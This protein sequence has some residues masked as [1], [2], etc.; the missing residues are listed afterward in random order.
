MAADRLKAA[1][2]VGQL[3]VGG[4]ERQVH[5]LTM[6][7]RE[8]PA[9]PL[10][11]SMTGRIA[12]FGTRLRESGV[13]VIALD[14]ARLGICG[15]VTALVRLLRRSDVHL[16]HSFGDAAGAFSAAAAAVT[17]IPHVHAVR[18]GRYGRPHAWNAL[19]GAVAHLAAAVTVNSHALR[20]EMVRFYRVPAS[21]VLL[22]PSGVDGHRFVG[23]DPAALRRTL[24]LSGAPQIVYVGRDHPAKDIPTLIEVIR[25]TDQLWPEST[26]APCFVLVGHGLESH[27]R[28]AASAVRRVTVRSLGV[29]HEVDRVIAACDILLLT[30]RSESM[31]NVVLEAMAAGKAVVATDAGG[32]REAITDGR[33]GRLARVGDARALAAALLALSEDDETRR[34]LGTQARLH[35]ERE[36]RVAAARDAV[37]AVYRAVLSGAVPRPSLRWR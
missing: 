28:H 7:L 15:R 25:R 23:L 16:V 5:T 27:A 8:T 10:V 37:C 2:V 6:A 18:S 19:R 14:D 12:P 34:A 35:V 1:L 32:T 3:S 36:F 26:V 24:G 33:T 11:V 20:E 31:P 4:T 21:R 17:R 13:C 9:Q 22:T 30:S 29:V